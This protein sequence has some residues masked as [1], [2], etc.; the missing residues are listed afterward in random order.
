MALCVEKL[1]EK[2]DEHFYCRYSNDLETGRRLP[3]A[4]LPAAINK[5]ER[6]RK[7][8][9]VGNGGGSLSPNA[10]PP[11][12]CYKSELN[13]LLSGF[14]LTIY[15]SSLDRSCLCNHDDPHALRHINRL[16]V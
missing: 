12:R 6:P 7:S 5:A 8:G 9:R 3:L 1:A 11:P 4:Y 14:F 2:E 15:I 10:P 16:P 13:S